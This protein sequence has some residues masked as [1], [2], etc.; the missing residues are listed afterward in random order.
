MAA[1]FTDIDSDFASFLATTAASASGPC[2]SAA[3]N[4]LLDERIHQ[5]RAERYKAHGAVAGHGS[6]EAWIDFHNTYLEE[7]IFIRGDDFVSEPPKNIDPKDFEVCPDT[8][9][10]PMLSSLGK[11]LDSDLIRVQKV[12]SVGNVLRKLEE[13]ISE[14]DILTLAKDALTKDQKALQELEGLLQAFASG[15]NWQPVFAGVW[16]D[17]SDLF[18]DAPKQDSSDWPNTLRDRLGLYH[19]DPKQSDPI[20]ILVF[21]YPAQAVPRLSGLDGESRPLTI[22]CVLDGGFSDAFCP[23]PQESDTGY[24]MS[25]READCSKLAREVLHP[26]MRLRAGHLFRVGAITHPIDPGTIKEQRGL[27]LACLQDISKRPE[28]GRHTD[29]DLF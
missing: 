11:T 1:L 21:R 9:R 25:L 7:E 17:L 23:A 29:E 3:R 26:A 5:T 8:F 15:R 24:T 20:H 12:S 2:W 22:P 13:N 18:G 27:H 19:Y 6:I 4:F 16:K 14:Q 28:Y 10:F